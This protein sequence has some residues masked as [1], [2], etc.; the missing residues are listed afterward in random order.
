MTARLDTVRSRQGTTTCG[1]IVSP[2]RRCRVPVATR[3]GALGRPGAARA[4]FCLYHRA[5][6]RMRLY[7][8]FTSER[9]AF[10]TWIERYQSGLRE[11]K[12]QSFWQQDR[13]QL[14]RVI[15]GQ[16]SWP[17]SCALSA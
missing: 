6:C 7:G 5:R 17:E 15:D 1:W 10:L 13:E 2:G 8:T 4:P 16:V 14:W 9:Q 12:H 11:T 3:R